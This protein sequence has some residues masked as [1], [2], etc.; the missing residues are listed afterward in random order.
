MHTGS[1]AHKVSL[2]RA[3][4]AALL[5]V[6]ITVL[7]AVAGYYFGDL[8]VSNSDTDVIIHTTDLYRGCSLF[9]EWL[10]RAARL[11]RP[12]LLQS[13]LLWLAPYTKLEAPI[14]SA[15]FMDR[16]VSLGLALRFSASEAS[17]LSIALLP[18]L[19]TMITAVFIL[20]T[21]SLH[22]SRTV[23]PVRDTCVQFLIAS[24]FTFIVYIASSWI[25]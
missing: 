23:R 5:A 21:Y 10:T 14:S 6:V 4:S 8:Y 25:L 19:H 15:V 11:C 2:D 7:S 24:G 20:F 1:C 17:D 12:M 18:L 9:V 3:F 16:G 13:L 22:D